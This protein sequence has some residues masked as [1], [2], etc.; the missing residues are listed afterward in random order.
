MKKLNLPYDFAVKFLNQSIFNEKDFVEKYKVAAT[1]GVPVKMQYSASL[2]LSPSDTVGMSY[3][4]DDILGLGKKN[5]VTPLIS[6][7]TQSSVENKGGKPT[8][9][10]KGE[11]LTEAGEQTQETDQNLNK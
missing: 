3:I 11:G 6:S 7:N 2:G 9:E 5:W 4:E 10:S 1:Y 8:N